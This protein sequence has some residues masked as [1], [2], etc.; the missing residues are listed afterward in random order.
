MALAILATI[1]L[2]EKSLASNDFSSFPGDFEKMWQEELI[3]CEYALAPSAHQIKN[4]L[5]RGKNPTLLTL[6]RKEILTKTPMLFEGFLPV[7][8]AG[9]FRSNL[10]ES[11][12][13]ALASNENTQAAFEA[14]LGMPVIDQHDYYS[15]KEA[16]SIVKCYR[17]LKLAMPEKM[18]AK[19][20]TAISRGPLDVSI[21]NDAKHSMTL[22]SASSPYNKIS[23][24]D[25]SYLSQVL[26]R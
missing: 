18:R 12:S 13:Q 17:A 10:K 7:S 23:D 26:S 15:Q 14:A 3:Y 20:Y 6:L 21:S 2:Y 25:T 1:K 9:I 16:L 19:C 24:D 22:F 8:A 5:P 11:Q 4:D